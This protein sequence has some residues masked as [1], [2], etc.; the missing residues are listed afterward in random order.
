MKNIFL[1]SKQIPLE[2]QSE[3]KRFKKYHKIKY[4]APYLSSPSGLGGLSV[5]TK[6]HHYFT[7]KQ[8]LV[9]LKLLKPELK[10]MNRTARAQ[11]LLHLDTV[12][13]K[14]PKDIRMGRGKGA[15][16]EKV[17]VLQAGKSLFTIYGLSEAKAQLFS[18]L[19]LHK[20]AV[21]SLKIN[22]HK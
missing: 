12:I 17:F 19:I 13:T 16:F 3:P 6:K 22:N 14:K 1:K 5:V 8:L 9:V 10:K 20:M 15:P 2:F 4:K 21:D 11:L 18:D 7:L